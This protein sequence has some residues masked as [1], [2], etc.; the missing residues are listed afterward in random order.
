MWERFSYYGM[1]GL[2]V[3]FLTNAVV[4]GGFGLDDQT[5]AAIYGLYTAGVY[6]LALPGGWVADRLVGQR[7]AV[8][9]GGVLIAAGHFSM[10]LASTATFFGGLVLIV[11]GTG[12]LKPNVSAVVGDLYP[13][14]GA[15]RDAGFSI[16][17]M[18]INIGAF[19][20][21]L[22]CGY[23]AEKTCSGRGLTFGTDC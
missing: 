23:L 13:E 17:Y 9:Y 12:L 14:K 5:A 19:T 18:G 2:L 4:T 21:P 16:F 3:L 10:A 7:R 22:V 15:R 8:L 20:G 11:L 6:L 1:R